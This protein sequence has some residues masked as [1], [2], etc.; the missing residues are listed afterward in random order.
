MFEPQALV[1][2]ELGGSMMAAP[3][4]FLA[5]LLDERQHLFAPGTD[6]GEIGERALMSGDRRARQRWPG[7]G[8]LRAVGSELTRQQVP[9]DHMACLLR[10]TGGADDGDQ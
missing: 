8:G 1:S 4:P 6:D 10:I 9:D 7:C 5:E 2:G 3:V